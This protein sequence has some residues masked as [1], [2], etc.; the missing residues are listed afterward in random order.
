ME[1]VDRQPYDSLPDAERILSEAF[2]LGGHLSPEARKRIWHKAQSAAQQPRQRA[3]LFRAVLYPIFV[4][5][6]TFGFLGGY[7]GVVLASG[8]SVP[9]EPL[10]V[11]ERGVEA[12][13]LKL[14]P[15]SRR[16][17]VQLVLLERRIYEAR[18]L[19]DV[20]QPVSEGLLQELELLFG[21]IADDSDCMQMQDE[22]IL[23]RVIGY[24]Q[25]VKVL[26]ER[27]PGVWGLDR[28][29]AA[30]DVAVVQFGGEPLEEAPP[31]SGWGRPVACAAQRRT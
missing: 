8:A 23:Q 17:E 9:G 4:L 13:W 26:A 19:L 12:M 18:A 10:Y 5:L 15:T 21:A 27:Y 29:L 25:K 2:A 6:L 11:V 20:G 7:V 16:C 31:G 3:H 14:T 1:R 30:A 24:R 28:V 22:G